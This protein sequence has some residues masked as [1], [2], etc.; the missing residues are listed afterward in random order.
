MEQ[1]GSIIKDIRKKNNLTQNEFA[2][3]LG[4][5][6]QAV[7]KWENDKSI[8]DITILKDI[9]NKFNVDLNYLIS[10]K[11]VNIN[12]KSFFKKNMIII[13]V[14]I[15]IIIS[16]CVFL[17][18]HKHNYEFKTLNGETKDIK[19]TGS[20]TYDESKSSIYLNVDYNADDTQ[21]YSYIKCTLYE[22]HQ[23]ILNVISEKEYLEKTPVSLKEYLKMISFVIDNY[24][25]S[26]KYYK[27]SN[28]Y[29]EISA[30]I[31]EEKSVTYKV[32]IKFNNC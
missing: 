6:F 16:V 10:G 29:L 26:C 2:S 4:V 20:I 3:I 23:D 15:F 27:D 17:F 22:K 14:I 5:T 13:T 28:L 18:F 12:K 19:V 24:S 9:S 30:K 11:K 1:I 8:P 25:P 21:K 7:S 32:P 31:D